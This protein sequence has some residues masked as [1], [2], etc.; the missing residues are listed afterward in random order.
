MSETYKAQF[1][2]E[3]VFNDPV[4]ITMTLLP[5]S[6]CIGRLVQVRKSVGQY[7]TDVLFIRM[8][9]ES[10]RTFENV[11]IEE[12]TEEELP[13]YEEDSTEVEYTIADE[14]P[15]VGFVIEEPKQPQSYSPPFGIAIT[16]G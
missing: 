15:E 1:G 13:V 3:F 5:D 12:Y 14:W 10:L 6:E 8:P 7:G 2:R 16:K 11:G 4:K 9:D